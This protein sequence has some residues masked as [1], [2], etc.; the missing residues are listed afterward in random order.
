MHS[1]CKMWVVNSD[2]NRLRV[3]SQRSQKHCNGILSWNL[4]LPTTSC[5]VLL[6][7]NLILLNWYGNFDAVHATTTINDRYLVGTNQVQF[8]LQSNAVAYAPDSPDIIGGEEATPG[9]WPWMVA[10]VYATNENVAQGQF[11]GGAL[12]DAEWVVTAAHCTHNLSGQPRTAAEIDVVIG[13]HQ[14]DADDG[15]R[16][17]VEAIIRHPSYTGNTFNND[18]ALLKLA[19]AVSYKPIAL[20][21]TSW[22]KLE[23]SGTLATVTGWGITEA[24][25]VSNVLRQVE[26][27]LVDQ[28]ICRQSYGL[29][30]EKVTDT[31]I[32]AGL[33]AGGQDSCQGDSGGPLMVFDDG[34][35][36]WTQ[37]G[38]VSWGDGCA[39]ANYYGVYTRVSAYTEWIH[40]QIT[41]SVTAT[42]TP[43]PLP[44]STTTM[45]PSTEPTTSATVTPTPTSTFV[46]TTMPTTM[47][48]PLPTSTSTF[49]PTTYPTVQLTATPLSTAEPTAVPAQLSYRL[50]LPIVAKA[51]FAILRGSS[52]EQDIN[53]NWTE[54]SL[55]GLSLIQDSVTAGV[56]ARSGHQL[57][58]LGG[59]DRETAYVQQIISVPPKEPIFEYWILIHS[60]DECGYDFGGVVLHNQHQEIVLD[61]FDLCKQTSSTQWQLRQL[62]LQ[63]YAGKTVTLAIRAETDSFL[64]STLLVD[65]VRFT[66]R[67]TVVHASFVASRE[68]GRNDKF[69]GMKRM[70]PAK[71]R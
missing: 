35:Q 51:G 60:T 2:R 28:S 21:V 30:T 42:V 3:F 49:V 43:S 8:Y 70:W 71:P 15:L 13:Q 38:I 69:S 57:A 48:T 12:I 17:E 20:P 24:G 37:I 4:H 45:L 34:R 44:I 40:A 55:Q 59:V 47:A 61:K 67:L 10:L 58:V 7:A 36:Q 32:C 62:D 14:L 33:Q 9:N 46:A 26:V 25:R 68:A 31:M 5:A 53:T 65:D 22:Q 39:E 6:I 56:D 11:C 63:Q 29:F 66:A 54:F 41:P 19:T 16:V 27:P 52:F 50:F 1:P 18:I 64:S 23:S